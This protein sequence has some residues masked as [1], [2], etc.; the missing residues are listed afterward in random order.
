MAVKRFSAF[1]GVFTPTFLSILGVIMYL[2]LGWVVGN[3]GLTNGL[4]IITIANLITLFT[5]LSVSSIATNMRIGTG[6]AYSIISKSLG[7]E[8]GGAIG[9]PLYLSQAISVAFYV[10]GF[11]ECWVSVFPRHDFLFVS[12][13]SWLVL[14]II[15]Y[16]SARFAFRLQYAIIAI[17]VFSL[18][19]FFLGKSTLIEPSFFRQGLKT[20]SFW[21]VFAVFFPAVTGILSGLSM[22][23]EL[24]KPERDIPLGMLSAVGVTFII[25]LTLA[26][27]F[28]YAASD[29]TLV[30]NTSVIIDLGRWKPIIVAGIMG[31][32]ISSALSMFVASPRTLLALGKYRTIPLAHNFAHINKRGEPTAA[33]LFTAC[34]SLL[35]IVF[36][37]LNK[38]AGLLTMFFLITYG[39]LNFSVFIEQIIGI[40]SFRPAFKVHTIF[41]FLGGVG[42]VFAMFLINPLFSL[43][44]ILVIILIYII[45]IQQEV[46]ENWPDVRKGLFIFIAEQAMKVSMSL[47][48]HP[49]IWKP[50]LLIPVSEPKEW[51]DM[52]EF[53]R[54]ITFPS[55]RVTFFKIA[56]QAGYTQT[57]INKRKQ[58]DEDFSL[59]TAPLR[60]EG[61]LADSVVVGSTDFLEGAT[62][63][64]QTLEAS[65]F[66]P[67]IFMVKL[68]LTPQQ[69]PDLKKLIER[70]E[71]LD[72]GVLILALH[73]TKEFGQKQMIN[74]WLREK[75]PN[76]DLAVLIAL[77]IQKNWG[78]KIRLIQAVDKDE[79]KSK[80]WSYLYRVKKIMRIPKETENLVLV[81]NFEEAIASAP[82]ADI[83]MFGMPEEVNI[84]EKRKIADKIDTSLLFFRDSKHESAVA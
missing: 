80:A 68:G 43:V 26:F 16:T 63:V 45:L 33:I 78:A 77:K 12:I 21:A 58:I 32:A 65:L 34:L 69:D 19:S 50:N 81:G 25:Y 37:T 56:S 13:A 18:V 75:S 1:E 52:T 70:M 60:E 31:A 20:L 74:V 7:L 84:A 66:A 76:V 42:C 62:I 23:G 61:I 53:I 41:P 59:L 44:A 10:T 40:G 29:Q 54:A 55:G 24:K 5:C 17:V 2:R 15:S 27:K 28:A 64:T 4:L 72:L 3:V 8:V 36:G 71:A 83:N 22:S 39:M 9:I 14:L 79:D 6:G 48:Y 57:Q 35:A 49:K 67:N 82:V 47:P 51:S 11:T 46:R 30:D 38:I 73:P